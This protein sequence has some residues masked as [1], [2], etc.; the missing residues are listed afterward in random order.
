MLLLRKNIGAGVADSVSYLY[1]GAA[2]LCLFCQHMERY[3][4]C[5]Y[6]TGALPD[7]DADGRT[8]PCKSEA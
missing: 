4:F 3:S 8:E 1:V 5:L 2:A 6:F 7:F